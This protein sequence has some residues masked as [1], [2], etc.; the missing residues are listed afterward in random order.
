MQEFIDAD[1]PIMILMYIKSNFFMTICYEQID[2]FRQCQNY[3]LYL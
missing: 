2:D 1:I 3:A